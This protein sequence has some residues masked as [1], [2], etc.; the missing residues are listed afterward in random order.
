MFFPPKLSNELGIILTN[1]H[2]HLRPSQSVASF[3]LSR[4]HGSDLSITGGMNP[5]LLKLLGPYNGG[6]EDKFISL[7]WVCNVL[8]L[9]NLFCLIVVLIKFA[10][11][12]AS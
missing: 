2:Y 9:I 4:Q 5:E 1:N 6:V 7:R 3:F 12:L 8:F 10:I 11:V